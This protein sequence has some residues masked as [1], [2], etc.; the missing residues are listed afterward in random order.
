MRKITA[1]VL[2]LVLLSFAVCSCEEAMED[3]PVVDL[4]GGA[5]G[6][7]SD[8]GDTYQPPDYGDV[9]TDTS[10]GSDSYESDT[11]GRDPICRDVPYEINVTGNYAIKSESVYKIDVFIGSSRDT[12]YGRV[13]AF[14]IENGVP[15]VYLDVLD[16][17]QKTVLCSKIF[18][19]MCKVFMDSKLE[20]LFVYSAT[21]NADGRCV[22][23]AGEYM[24]SDIDQT[25]LPL[26]N[27]G[28]IGFVSA[29]RGNS[30][31]L[32]LT[33]SESI[34]KNLLQVMVSTLDDKTS[35]MYCTIAD[36]VSQPVTYD[37]G[38]HEKV[39]S[40]EKYLTWEILKDYYEQLF[41]NK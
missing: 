12:R 9:Y 35:D 8:V 28:E 26:G 3:L 4:G 20:S 17:E 34:N 24:V 21:V 31:T 29:E 1:C 13:V 41:A 40:A 2:C 30:Q 39:D 14:L 37:V 18:N 38:T 7:M 22:L 36:T 27:N 32:Q 23:N 6:K 16:K 11:D 33:Q 10:F 15:A 5:D 25:G 19:G